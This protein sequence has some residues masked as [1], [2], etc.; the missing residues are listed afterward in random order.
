MD[1]DRFTKLVDR[2]FEKELDKII[3]NASWEHALILFK[4]LF[5]AALKYDDKNIRIVSGH[6]TREF[7]RELVEEVRACLEKGVHVE[8]LVTEPKAD[9]E[10]NEFVRVVRASPNGTVLVSRKPLSTSHFIVVGEKRFRL[11]EDH[12]Q[13]KA[14]A[15]F[16]NQDIA[17]SLIDVFNLIKKAVSNHS[18]DAAPACR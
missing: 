5:K 16:K 11:E 1:N 6:L 9:I 10:D 4:H 17:K 12:K 2:C 15:C 14:V 13:C 7:Y 8:V 3:Y 18:T